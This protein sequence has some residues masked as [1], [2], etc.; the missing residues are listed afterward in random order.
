M[1]VHADIPR[2]LDL[3]RQGRL[4]LGEL[5]TKTYRLEEVNDAFADMTAGATARSLIVF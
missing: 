5:V 2:L 4:K 1:K 3:Y